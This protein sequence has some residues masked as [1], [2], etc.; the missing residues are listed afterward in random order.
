MADKKTQFFLTSEV[1]I[2]D[3]E[4]FNNIGLIQALPIIPRHQ[5]S[6]ASFKRRPEF[7]ESL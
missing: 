3:K 7:K 2:Q 6:T 5:N 1:K 4:F